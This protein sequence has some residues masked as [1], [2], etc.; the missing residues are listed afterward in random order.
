MSTPIPPIIKLEYAPRGARTPSA[1]GSRA[2]PS[3][4]PPHVPE[5]DQLRAEEGNQPSAAAAKSLCAGDTPIDAL[6]DKRLVAGNMERSGDVCAVGALGKARGVDM[7]GYPLPMQTPMDSRGRRSLNCHSPLCS[8]LLVL[9]S[10]RRPQSAPNSA[11]RARSTLELAFLPNSPSTL[12]FLFT[13]FSRCSSSRRES[14]RTSN[15]RSKTLHPSWS[16]R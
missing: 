10:E 16:L 9:A 11:F 15:E 7:L 6:P 5:C 4:T 3:Q 12:P 8:L 1:P 14:P 2:S 13:S